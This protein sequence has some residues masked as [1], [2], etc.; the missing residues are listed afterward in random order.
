MYSILLNFFYFSLLK[1]TYIYNPSSN[2]AETVL[3]MAK[4]C[5]FNLETNEWKAEEITGMDK[6]ETVFV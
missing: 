4:Q 2:I 1:N 6:K 3:N 5:G